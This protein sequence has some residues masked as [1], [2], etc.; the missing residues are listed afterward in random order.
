[1]SS[2]PVEI[3]MYSLE[4]I[5]EFEKKYIFIAQKIAFLCGVFFY[6]IKTIIYYTARFREFAVDWTGNLHGIC[7]KIK[8]DLDGFVQRCTLKVTRKIGS[9]PRSLS[10]QTMTNAISYSHKQRWDRHE[11][12]IIQVL[13]NCLQVINYIFFDGVSC[14]KARSMNYSSQYSQA[15]YI[16][17]SSS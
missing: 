14:E 16:A 2:N 9:E 11:L 13:Y 12:V 10:I 5:I 15:P 8:I 3:K 4:S 1:M 17:Q 7:S 6:L